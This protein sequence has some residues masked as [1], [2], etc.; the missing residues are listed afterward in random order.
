M[1]SPFFDLE[2]CLRQ[3]GASLRTL[4][5]SL[6]RDSH[7]AD[8]A[9][10]E[11]WLAALRTPPGHGG[12]VGGWLATALQNIARKLRRTE[13]R[14]VAREDTVAVRRGEQVEDHAVASAREELLQR[15][16]GAVTSLNAPYREAIW[17]RYFEG[18][19]P[20]AIAARTGVPVATVKSR[21]Q[22]GL[23]QLRK[24]LGDGDPADWRAGLLV[25]FGWQPGTGAA[26]AVGGG[27]AMATLWPGVLAMAKTTKSLVAVL[28]VAMTAGLWWWYERLHAEVRADAATEAAFASRFDESPLPQG[29]AATPAGTTSSGSTER[30]LVPALADADP[31]V[32]VRVVKADGLVAPGAEV[33][34]ADQAQAAARLA[35]LDPE[36]RR[37]LQNDGEALLRRFG[38]RLVADDQGVVQWP[39]RSRERGSWYATGR[40]GGQFG[41]TWVSMDLA[42][43]ATSSVHEL[44]LGFDRRFAVQVF[45]AAR[46]PAAGVDLRAHFVRSGTEPQA[47]SHALGA[48]GPDGRF[49]AHHVQTWGDRIAPQ[50]AS[51][52]ARIAVDLP[53]VEL[54]EAATQQSV[55]VASPPG[56]LPPLF[57]PPTGRIVVAV[58]D[59][60]G[61]PMPGQEVELLEDQPV[62]G[63]SFHATSDAAG[64]A[65]FPYVGLGRSWRVDKDHLPTERRLLVAGPRVADEVVRVTLQPL[66][67]PVLTGR[68]L[69]EGSPAAD[70]F[71]RAEAAGRYLA[72]GPL[73]TDADGRFRIS[74]ADAAVGRTLTEL[75]LRPF[76]PERLFDG[77]FA[78]WRGDRLL[79]PGEHDLGALPLQ[80]E[81]VVVAGRCLVAGEG[82]EPADVRLVVEASTGPPEAPWQVVRLSPQREADGRFALFGT[83]PAAALRL[84]VESDNRLVPI[85]PIPF[86]RGAR[87]LRIELRRG[88]SLRASIV[89]GSQIGG[90]CLVPLLVPAGV[91]LDLPASEQFQP[92]RD[93]RVPRNSVVL[94][95]EPWETGYAWPAVAPGR[96]RLE[97]RARGLQRPL[98]VVGDI[99]IVDGQCNEEAR[100]QHLAVPG[101]RTVELQLPQVERAVRAP[102]SLG[103]GLVAALDG[104]EF[105]E[106]CWQIDDAKVL[107]ATVEPLDVRVRLHGFQDRILRGLVGD[108]VVELAPG[109]PVTLRVVEFQPPAGTELRLAV[110]AVDDPLTRARPAVY[111]AAAGGALP[112]YRLPGF[113][114]AVAD[115]TVQ[116]AL[117]V[118]GRYRLSAQLRSP[119]GS[120]RD[121]V[122]APAEVA[123]GATG[124]EFAVRVQE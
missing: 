90:F 88:G 112:P 74:L 26:A 93:P 28:V 84:V 95:D 108:Q 120:V 70:L 37:A 83:A 18:Q 118:A 12:S 11:V 4:A 123:V 77:T 41:E 29:D 59:A 51:L 50:G 47:G 72:A 119:D 85:A 117:P 116:V 97:V 62:P 20:R 114:G 101:L 82:A 61:V 14:R 73:R 121:L 17:Q 48:T 21:L 40:L 31:Q 75:S 7:A 69:R 64:T 89:A 3:H 66:G 105:G 19:A 10:Q 110:A 36:A 9:V 38:E 124:G 104:E 53:G 54:H 25:A 103:L 122:V 52:L 99:E 45:Y 35:E 58:R 68:L 5:A 30:T 2:S 98:L 34:Y 65:T 22:R 107:F 55:D 16:V 57:L 42:A 23:E 100:L 80:P 78:Q 46:Q 102:G 115:G 44:R 32:V 13:R 87:D 111:S 63:R 109:L 106:P 33:F 24:R 71:L 6:L 76:A 15:L 91:A 56:E 49:V 60:S 79:T 1:D 67:M 43:G 113:G 96:Y 39:W 86:V 27:S 81:P 8:D 92:G 94:R